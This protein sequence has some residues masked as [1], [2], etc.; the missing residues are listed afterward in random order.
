MGTLSVQ[1][2]TLIIGLFAV[3]VPAYLNSRHKR[4]DKRQKSAE[5]LLILANTTNIQD[6]ARTHIELDCM[7]DLTGVEQ[8]SLSF[9]TGTEKFKDPNAAIKTF[10]EYSKFYPTFPHINKDTKQK[11]RWCISAKFIVCS[12]FFAIVSILSLSLAISTAGR[13]SNEVSAQKLLQKL[14]ILQ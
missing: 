6:T 9:F 3:F 8:G 5:L 13:I 1:L 7:R 4:I 11:S 14:N 12:I 10:L 2:A